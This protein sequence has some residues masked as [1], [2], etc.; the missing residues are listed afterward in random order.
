MN[1]SPAVPPALSP[2]VS[3]AVSPAGP[4]AARPR[5]SAYVIAFNEAAKIEAAVSSLLWADEIVVADS[6]STDGTAEIAT[7]L[8]ARVVQIP[9]AGFG[10]LR[11]RAIAHCTGE[12]IFSLDADERCTPEVRDEV[13]RIVAADGPADLWF[14]PRRN[15]FLG[16][17]IRGSGWYPNY[18]QPQLFRN[19]RMAYTM[20]PVHEG[21]VSRS[22]RPPGHLTEAIWQIPFRDLEEV[23]RKANR[24]SSLG[25]EKLAG[26]RIGPGAALAHAT[27]AFLKHYVF[28]RGFLDGWPGFVIAFGN[29]EG[30]FWRYAKRWE[31]D[32]A[33]APPPVRRVERPGRT[34][35]DSTEDFPR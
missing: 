27:W 17:W 18:R 26:R 2:A 13:L 24:Y 25:A 5:V 35:Q 11:N 20:D 34:P 10:D 33:F 32:A 4:V 16:R 22:D 15:W 30:T 7:A 31:R 12:W 6:G 21:F 29:F 19:G 9:F 1:E 3:P 28:K 14:V 8:G 23:V